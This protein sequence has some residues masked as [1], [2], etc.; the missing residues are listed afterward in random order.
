MMVVA[1]S[2]VT[3]MT[4]NVTSDLADLHTNMYPEKVFFMPWEW[5]FINTKGGIFTIIV[6]FQR[7]NVIIMSIAL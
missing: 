4:Y 5:T 1:T 6:S 3:M 2:G 7:M